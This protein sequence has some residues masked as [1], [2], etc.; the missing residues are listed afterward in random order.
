[1]ADAWAEFDEFKETEIDTGKVTSA[2]VFGT[3]AFLKSNYLDRMAGAVLGIYG[4]SKEEAMYRVYSVDDGQ[5][6]D[7]RRNTLHPALRAR[8][9]AAGQRLL[10]ADDVRAAGEPA[11]GQSAQPLPDQLADAAAA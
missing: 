1:M 10:V 9:A 5:K 4:N 2:D 8:P 11:R 6:L 3:R 7:Q